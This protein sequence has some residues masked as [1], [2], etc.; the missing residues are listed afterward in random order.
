MSHDYID[1]V[2]DGPPSHESGRFVEVEDSA[3]KSVNVGT[4]IQGDHGF[5]R[6]RIP[7]QDERV[8]E[9]EKERD[10]GHKVNHE[11][12]VDLCEK[13]KHIAKLEALVRRHG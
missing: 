12:A 6:L 3:G 2:F 7:M 5:W 8:A 9:L 11:L 4:W 13:N 10:T 1:N